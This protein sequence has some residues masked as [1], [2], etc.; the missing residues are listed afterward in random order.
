MLN[1]KLSSNLEKETATFLLKEFKNIS[2]EQN[3]YYFFKKYMTKSEKEK[4]FKRI[5]TLILLNKNRKYRDIKKIL[6][7]SGDNISKSRDVLNGGGYGENSKRKRRYSNLSYF[8]KSS[9]RK[10]LRYKGTSG[11]FD[12]FV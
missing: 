4:F 11:L 7:V 10:R 1:K 12:P 5:A 3:V 2:S 6:N 9:E 8:K